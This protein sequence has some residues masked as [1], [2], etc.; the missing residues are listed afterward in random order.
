MKVEVKLKHYDYRIL[1]GG[2][3]CVYIPRKKFR[4]FQS[5]A[6]D[7]GFFVIEFYSGKRKITTEWDTKEKW[8]SVLKELHKKL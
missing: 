2:L 6:D 1:I 7:E 4:G 3:P 8:I 5:W